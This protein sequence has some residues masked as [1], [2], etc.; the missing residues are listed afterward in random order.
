MKKL[1]KKR[2]EWI[3]RTV[4]NDRS[5]KAVVYNRFIVC[6]LLIILQILLYIF[7]LFTTFEKGGWVVELLFFGIS[8]ASFLHLI[9]HHKNPST[10]LNWIILIFVAPLLGGAMYVLYGEGRLMKGIDKKLQTEKQRLYPLLFREKS[11]DAPTG[12]ISGYLQNQAGYPAYT[13]GDICYYGDG[14]ELYN[15][16][17]ASIQN[18]K[19]FILLEYF[20]VAGGKLWSTLLQA[21]LQKAEEGIEIKMIYEIISN[22]K[23]TIRK[24]N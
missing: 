10:R 14:K 12:T 19:K 7:L 22:L 23:T 16:M 3:E 6:A 4:E 5:Y 20:I 18:A 15:Q 1:T 9:S 8:S 21:L 24:F 17:L 13:D 11:L 2:K